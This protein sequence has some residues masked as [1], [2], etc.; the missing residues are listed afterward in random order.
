ML[1]LLLIHVYKEK[2]VKSPPLKPLKRDKVNESDEVKIK[3]G[4]TLKRSG[5][6]IR[7]VRDTN[8]VHKRTWEPLS[9]NINDN[10]N[11][12][13]SAKFE[14]NIALAEVKNYI[15]HYRLLVCLINYI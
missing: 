9:S 6:V 2:I 13:S 5:T 14:R 11:L 12:N 1:R 8:S 7:S 3:E 15:A 10:D 4:F